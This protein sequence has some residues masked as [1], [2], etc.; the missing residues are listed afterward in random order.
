MQVSQDNHNIKDLPDCL[1]EKLVEKPLFVAL[2]RDGT[3]VPICEKP[4][5]AIL[6]DKDKITITALAKCPKVAVAIVSARSTEKLKS[7]FSEQNIILAGN[8]G[9]EILYPNGKSFLHPQA[10]LC[11]TAIRDLKQDL[12]AQLPPQLPYILDDHTFSLCLHYHQLA[13][14]HRPTITQR[15]E[16]LSSKYSEILLKYLPT[17]LE[18]LPE[19][20][21]SKADGLEE[22]LN[23]YNFGPEFHLSIYIGDSSAD[24]PAFSWTNARK[25]IS[26]LIGKENIGSTAAAYNLSSPEATM[27]FLEKLLFVRTNA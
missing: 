24:E 18:F 5:L 27:T 3:L 7:D 12:L 16:E 21:W 22:I 10:E 1:W 9:L 26:I 14:E 15:A 11:R 19:I 23:Y 25:G 8:Y 4:E 20:N 17:S 2:D 13:L 6:K